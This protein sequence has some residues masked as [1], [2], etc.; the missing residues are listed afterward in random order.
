[1][2]AGRVFDDDQ[3]RR[4]H[5]DAELLA[6]RGGVVEQALLERRIAPCPGDDTRA[7]RRGAH[8]HRLDGAADIVRSDDALPDQQ[9][10]DGDL[11]A[12]VIAETF[13]RIGPGWMSVIVFIRMVVCMVVR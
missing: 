9:L 11:H 13:R 3:P 4:S 2:D 7:L 12:L 1:V 10:A 8:I 5:R 6:S